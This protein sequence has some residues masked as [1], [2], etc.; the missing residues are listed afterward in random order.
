MGFEDTFRSLKIKGKFVMGSSGVPAALGV[1]GGNVFQVYGTSSA[2]AADARS[3][4]ARLYLTGIGGSGEAV[5]SF[6]TVNAAGSTAHGLHAS[7]SFGAGGSLTGL[8]VAARA[9]LQVKNGAMTG[10][11]FSALQA[12]IYG[13]GTSSSVSGMTECS[14]LRFVADGA[15][16]NVKAT[17]DTSG[18]LFSIQ[19]LSVASGKLFQ[20]NT[21]GAASHALRIKVGATPY[22]LMLTDTG[23]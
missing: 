6:T 8:G 18:F 11:T 23:A 9:T 20:A 5:R 21:A 10:G 15:T 12:E 19:G 17:I 4:Y 1:A 7:L 2:T 16:T 13:D 14:F 22:F 3:F